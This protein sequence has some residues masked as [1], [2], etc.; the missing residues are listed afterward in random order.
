MKITDYKN[1]IKALPYG[2]H[3][4]EIKRETWKKI[5][6]QKEIIASIFNGK[7]TVTIKRKRKEH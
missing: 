7:D 1:L 6:N 5:N 3:S 4:F 2:E